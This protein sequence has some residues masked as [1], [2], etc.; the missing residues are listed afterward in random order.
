MVS[1][2]DTEIETFKRILAEYGY[3]NDNFELTTRQV[4]YPAR[5]AGGP[6]AVG[7]IAGYVTVKHRKTGIEYTYKVGHFDAWVVEFENHL[8]T[9]AFT[10]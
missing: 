5:R 10:S 7:P 1:I 9:K 3:T 2:F 8:K 4:R 6:T